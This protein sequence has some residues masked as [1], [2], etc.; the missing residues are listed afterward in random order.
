MR[1][2]IG[3]PL[4]RVGGGN[5]R[6]RTVR[7]A[8]DD[9]CGS[10]PAS[11]TSTRGVKRPTSTS[12]FA[13]FVIGVPAFRVW[14]TTHSWSAAQRIVRPSVHWLISGQSQKRDREIPTWNARQRPVDRGPDVDLV[15]LAR[16][17][18][19][20]DI[21]KTSVGDRVAG[22]IVRALRFAARYAAALIC[23]AGRAIEVRRTG[24]RTRSPPPTLR[25]HNPDE[26]VGHFTRTWRL[27]R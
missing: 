18:A 24:P 1:Q 10:T 17:V 14:L 6:R 16:T 8:E 12:V 19:S 15:T 4:V 25:P 2:E 21:E 13:N 23:I 5:H 7:V 20:G 26:R 3:P 27:S 11:E 22:S 9:H